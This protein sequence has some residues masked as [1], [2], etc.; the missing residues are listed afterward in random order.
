MIPASLRRI[1][2]PRPL[3]IICEVDTE[4][5]STSSWYLPMN[6]FRKR[7]RRSLTNPWFINFLLT[8]VTFYKVWVGAASSWISNKLGIYPICRWS[9]YIATKVGEIDKFIIKIVSY[10]IGSGTEMWACRQFFWKSLPPNST[11]MLSNLKKNTIIS[12]PESITNEMIFILKLSISSTLVT[13]YQL[14]L[15]MG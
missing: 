6:F 3:C 10:V 7:T 2:T 4:Y 5:L 9:W 14:H 13:I 15:H 11:N 12:V 1:Y 8:L